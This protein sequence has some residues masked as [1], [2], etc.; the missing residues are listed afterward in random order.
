[1]V[2]LSIPLAGMQQAADRLN[3]SASRIARAPFEA[4]NPAQAD[5][6]DLSVEM[7]GILEARNA[8]TANVNVA[9]V[10][11]EMTRATLELFG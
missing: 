9:K 10:G 5:T 1:M 6:I 8:F 11:D 7:V 4:L 3:L 2:D